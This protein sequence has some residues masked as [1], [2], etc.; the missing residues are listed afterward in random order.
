M[1]KFLMA[2][3][4]IFTLATAAHAADV[5][6][7]V[8]EQKDW[9]VHVGG[10][11]VFFNSGLTSTNV[12]AI[13]NTTVSDNITVTTEFGRYITNNI[14][15]SLSAGLP[16]TNDLFVTTGAG[17]ARTGSATYGSAILGGQYHFNRAGT[18]KPYLGGGVAYNII[19]GT[20]ST[21]ATPVNIDNGFG[22]VLQAGVELDVSSNVG[23]FMDVKKMFYT[24][25]VTK[26]A[27]DEQVRLDPWIVSAGLAFRF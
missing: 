14:S 15:L 18:V 12:P 16:P 24:A 9:F 25:H 2:S 21:N 27:I 17:T 26:G 11:G 20:T 8:M 4:A 23:V 1:K 22:A 13:L 5:A 19:F 6:P 3:A 10:A 7:V